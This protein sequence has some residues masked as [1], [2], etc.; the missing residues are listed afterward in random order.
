MTNMLGEKIHKLRKG[1]GLSQEELASKLTV[2]RQSIS[3]W[4]LGESVPDTEHVVQLSK[5]FEVSTDFL[6][7]DEYDSDSDIPAVKISNDKL[8]KKYQR[9]IKII[10]CYIIMGIGILGIVTILILSYVLP[11]IKMV[12]DSVGP[13]II[14]SESTH[15]GLDGDEL[16]LYYTDIEVRGEL[17]AF[18][19]TYK[20]MRLFVVCCVLVLVGAVLLLLVL[21]NEK[22]LLRKQDTK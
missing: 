16:V 14:D 10:S 4:E 17:G 8:K 7:N 9:K 5:L 20:L 19:D 15:L 1:N 6:L 12:P 2:S 21:C 18:L 3:K 11:S 22:L 13:P